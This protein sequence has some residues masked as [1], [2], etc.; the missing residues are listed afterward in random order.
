MFRYSRMGA[1]SRIT[2]VARSRSERARA[3][4]RERLHWIVP[5]LVI[6]ASVSVADAQPQI[7]PAT[8]DCVEVVHAEANDELTRYLSNQ[9][10]LR[11]TFALQTGGDYAMIGNLGMTE[12]ATIRADFALQ[13]IERTPIGNLNLTTILLSPKDGVYQAVHS[14]HSVIFGGLVPSQ[15]LLTCRAR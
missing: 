8:L 14:R 3:I 6:A 1:S 2:G 12:L 10:G 7:A 4:S 5:L 13:L 11:L 9:G 15:T